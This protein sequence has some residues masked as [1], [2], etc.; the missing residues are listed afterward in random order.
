MPDVTVNTIMTADPT[1]KDLVEFAKAKAEMWKKDLKRSQIRSIFTE[2][3]EIESEWEHDQIHSMRRLN[4]LK[5][6]L[7]YQQARHDKSEGLRGLVDTLTKA[8]EEVGRAPENE[9][10]DRFS[11]FM[12]LFEAILAYH[13]GG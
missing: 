9:R 4:L 12:E 6:K 11:R 2:A 5:A 1:G 8:I 3:R 7:A 10:T 13:R